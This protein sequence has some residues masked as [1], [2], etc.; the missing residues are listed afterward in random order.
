MLELGGNAPFIVLE[1]ADLEVA[2]AQAELG[3]LRNTGQSCVGVNRFLVHRSVAEEFS[4]RLAARFDELSIGPGTA[5][6][7]PDLGPVIDADRVSAVTSLVDS[8]IAAGGRRL[9]AERDLP[10]EGFWVAPTL[11]ADAPRDSRL[12]TE[13]VFG[14]AAGIFT[15]ET[16]AEAIQLANDT[17][18]GLAAYVITRDAGRA[19]RFAE[20]LDTGIIGIN[21]ALPTV[22]FTPMGG[23]KQSGLGREGAVEGLR[24]FQETAYIAWRP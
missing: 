12:A 4:S 5:D 17:E 6:P 20:R 16:D 10:A 18:M 23:T 21:D 1:D 9:T 8:A 7:V 13:E 3:K 24:E 19:L 11:I 22:A 14:P 15:F 2:L